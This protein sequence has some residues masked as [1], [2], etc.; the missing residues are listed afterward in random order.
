M[1]ASFIQNQVINAQNA[2][3]K[4]TALATLEAAEEAILEYA[5]AEV[6][7]EFNLKNDIS[8]EVISEK[9]PDSSSSYA[10][11]QNVYITDYL[12]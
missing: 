8:I 11:G 4:V 12:D 6:T 1:V 7:Y 3:T 2:K 10:F 9:Y 5:P